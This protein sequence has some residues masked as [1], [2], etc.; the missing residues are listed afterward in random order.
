MARVPHQPSKIEDRM[1]RRAA[2]ALR[3]CSV[4][5]PP[6]WADML[7]RAFLRSCILPAIIAHATGTLLARAL[8]VALL[9]ILALPTDAEARRGI[10]LGQIGGCFGA[11]E[12]IAQLADARL[13]GP[14]D[15]AL[16]IGRKT[17]TK[18]LLLPYSFSDDGYVLGI[19]DEPGRYYQFP[20]ADFVRA[21]QA[22]GLLPDPLPPSHV[23]FSDY[24][25]GHVLWLV[26]ALPLALL[27]L[28]HLMRRRRLRA[29]NE[30][31]AADALPFDP[32]PVPPTEGQ[33]VPWP[34]AAAMA[35]VARP[36]REETGR[37]G[38]TS[39]PQQVGEHVPD[40]V[41]DADAR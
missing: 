14:Y 9:V 29:A 28:V 39:G 12:E 41:R 19:A 32:L 7:A 21:A 4:G 2:L 35:P 34:G 24:L 16:F 11:G 18:C 40:D 10:R 25:W 15:E 31:A 22:E 27:L 23:H 30:A 8:L 36:D 33:S 38:P 37:V 6:G 1:S 13:Q 26:V 20:D 5:C 17:T 3:C